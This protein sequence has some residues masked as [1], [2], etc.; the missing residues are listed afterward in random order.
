[1]MVM[2]QISQSMNIGKRRK[3][4]LAL[5]LLAAIILMGGCSNDSHPSAHSASA[6]NVNADSVQ[7]VSFWVATDTHYLDKELQDGGT[8]FDA[9]VS[10]GDGKMLPYSEELMEAL[11]YDVEQKKPAFLILSGDLTN[12]GE[13]SS[14][15]KLV[16]KLKRIEQA[17]TSVYVIPGNHDLNNPWARSFSGDK[18]I[19]AEYLSDEDFDD[20]YAE[21]GYDEAF[22]RDEDSLSYLVQAAPGLWLLMIDSAQYAK[23]EEYG[24]PQTDG[25]IL[26]ST[27]AWMEKCVK[28]AA[29]S[30][31]SIITVMH[32]NLLDHTTMQVS[33]FRLNNSQEA[34]KLL[35]QGGLNL[36]LSGH[37][38]MQDIRRDPA[39]GE[40]D[41]AFPVYDIATGA[42]A[43]NPHQYGVM[44][45]DPLSRGVTYNTAAVDVEGWAAAT[46]SNDPNL[47]GFKSYA[48]KAFASS[49]YSKALQQLEDSSFSTADRASMAET[50]AKLNVYYFAGTAAE[51]LPEIKAMPGFKLWEQV[52]GGFMSGY[53]RSMVEE[54]DESNVSL[55]MVLNGNTQ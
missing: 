33:G 30:Q 45:F 54:Q 11:V 28:L 44:T 49:S 24:F 23:N 3:S 31:A 38:H 40:G 9:Y 12:N 14:H 13:A 27:Q 55:D 5:P 46:G 51:H 26:P 34:M 32:H 6:V 7:P 8:A 39:S 10:G 17:G 52:Q 36:V 1:M 47:L 21:Y 48:E 42:F 2:Q 41:E 16:E 29:K 50:M 18:Q 35:R 53:I 20:L 25:R 22:S 15:K 19:V 37:I 43:V 4:L